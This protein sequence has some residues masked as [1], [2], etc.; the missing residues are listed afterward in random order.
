MYAVARIMDIYALARMFRTFDKT[1][2]KDLKN[3]IVYVGNA[4]AKFYKMFLEYMNAD[5]IVEIKRKTNCYYVH[6][7]ESQ[8][9]K[10]FLFN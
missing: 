8:K 3:I 9:Q 7:S 5:K 10:S 2:D 6:F 4:H 1:P